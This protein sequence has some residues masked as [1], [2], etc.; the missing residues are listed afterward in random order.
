MEE[1]GPKKRWNCDDGFNSACRV[2]CEAGDRVIGCHTRAWTWNFNPFRLNFWHC[3]SVSYR[4]SHIGVVHRPSIALCAACWPNDTKMC[5]HTFLWAKRV[6]TVPSL[7]TRYTHTRDT[8]V[9]VGQC[10]VCTEPKID[11][12]TMYA[13]YRT[14]SA[15]NC[16]ALLCSALLVSA[17]C[18]HRRVRVDTAQRFNVFGII[19]K[20]H[21]K[22]T[23][24]CWKRN[25]SKQR[26]PEHTYQIPIHRESG[27][28]RRKTCASAKIYCAMTDF[29]GEKKNGFDSI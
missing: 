18:I 20:H 24:R 27:D 16:H 17:F 21:L 25:K 26:V 5:D 9:H 28:D 29:V 8:H 14:L 13:G 10:A 3:W 4:S 19:R 2:E 6:C 22:C 11:K 12:Q 7:C 1:K 15:R 23:E